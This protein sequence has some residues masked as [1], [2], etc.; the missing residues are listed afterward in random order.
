MR[1]LGVFC[2]DTFAIF[3]GRSCILHILPFAIFNG[4]L[5]IIHVPRPAL[6]RIKIAIH[7]ISCDVLFGCG[8]GR[9]DV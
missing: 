8:V 7:V 4:S 6:L 9:T 3:N 1:I 2:A 5:R